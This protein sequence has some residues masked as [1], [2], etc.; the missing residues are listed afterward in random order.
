MKS[1]TAGVILLMTC[2]VTKVHLR[3]QSVLR[4]SKNTV[5]L[6]HRSVGCII[7]FTEHAP[8]R[9]N[10]RAYTHANYFRRSV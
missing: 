8:S 7:S 1:R 6:I 9:G 4:I 3:N 5:G 2:S 10:Q